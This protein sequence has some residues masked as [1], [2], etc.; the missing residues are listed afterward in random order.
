MV[1]ERSGPRMAK[2]AAQSPVSVRRRVVA[3]SELAQ[4]L[5]SKKS[6]WNKA[7]PV[8]WRQKMAVPTVTGRRRWDLADRIEEN[9][10][11]GRADLLQRGCSGRAVAGVV[12]HSVVLL[13]PGPDSN[14][15]P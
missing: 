10:E 12:L 1:P 15:S 14:P 4:Y 11:D 2:S 6:C 8:L 13:D 3:G 7:S 9:V 5:E